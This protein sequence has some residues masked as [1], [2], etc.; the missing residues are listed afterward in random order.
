MVAKC[1]LKIEALEKGNNFASMRVAFCRRFE[2]VD[3]SSRKPLSI[4][5]QGTQVKRNLKQ[6]ALLTF[7]VA[8]ILAAAGEA[9][10][11][12]LDSYFLSQTQRRR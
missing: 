7:V 6:A 12:E 9:V 3:K 2:L 4:I 1:A 10:Y 11:L 5:D 8:L